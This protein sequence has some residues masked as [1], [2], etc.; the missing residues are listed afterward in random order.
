[1]RGRT[2]RRSRKAR[3]PLLAILSPPALSSTNVAAE[4]VQAA[5]LQARGKSPERTLVGP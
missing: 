5:A 3:A 4:M 2:T 1:M